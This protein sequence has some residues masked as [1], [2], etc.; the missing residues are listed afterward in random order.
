MPS[1]A[2]PAAS[3]FN[4]IQ[5]IALC[6]GKLAGP[7]VGYAENV[8]VSQK[9]KAEFQSM[10]NVALKVDLNKSPDNRQLNLVMQRRARWLLSRTD[11]LFPP[12][13]N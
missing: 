12:S 4:P 3:T 13:T 5:K 1:C 2:T 9:N 8:L 7:Y 10:L 6:G 11:K